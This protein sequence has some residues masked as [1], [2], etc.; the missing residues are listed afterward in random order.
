[1]QDERNR[2]AVELTRDQRDALWAELE[3]DLDGAGEDLLML[4]QTGQ[5]AKARKYRRKLEAIFALLDELGWAK[6]DERQRFNVALDA[7]TLEYL[8]ARREDNRRFI[9]HH[10]ES[11][12]AIRAGDSQHHYCGMDRDESEAQTVQEIDGALEVVHAMDALLVRC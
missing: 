5:G 1:M 9:A 11:L 7:R 8:R 12:K 2:V 4:V 6:Y 3:L 10:H